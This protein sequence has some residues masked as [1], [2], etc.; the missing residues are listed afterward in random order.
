MYCPPTP[1]DVVEEFPLVPT[2]ANS[3]V[4]SR[5]GGT[6]GV[7]GG[8]WAMDVAGAIEIAK[9]TDEIRRRRM[10]IVTG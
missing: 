8:G 2:Y 3:A 7:P 5:R 6:G 10:C 4:A 1:M 9:A